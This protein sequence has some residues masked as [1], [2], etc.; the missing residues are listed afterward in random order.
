MA[1]PDSPR[2]RV[3]EF[4]CRYC[5]KHFKRLEHV[6]RHERTHTREAPFQC[7]CG[8]AFTRRSNYRSDKL[9]SILTIPR[10]LLTRHEKSAHGGMSRGRKV[11]KSAGLPHPTFLVQSDTPHDPE[12]ER[13]SQQTTFQSNTNDRVDFTDEDTI[14]VTHDISRSIAPS[15]GAEYTQ[16]ASNPGLGLVEQEANAFGVDA[17]VPTFLYDNTF[18][19]EH[20]VFL[21]DFD[22]SYFIQ[23]PFQLPGDTNTI[24]PGGTSAFN[25]PY[26]DP[27]DSAAEGPEDHTAS[28]SRFGS[29][30]PS[31]EPHVLSRTRRKTNNV[32]SSLPF[33]RK[34]T[35]EEYRAIE[36]KV[37]DWGDFLTKNFEL[38]S[39]HTLSR[40]FEGCMYG[41]FE[42]LPFVHIPTFSIEESSLELLLSIAAIGAEFRFERTCAVELFYAA[43]AI[44]MSPKSGNFYRSHNIGSLYTVGGQSFDSGPV[45]NNL[46]PNCNVSLEISS[47]AATSNHTLS[48]SEHRLQRIQAIL[49]IMV[50]GSWSEKSLVREA[51]SLQ[52]MLALLVRE[53]NLMEEDDSPV[54]YSAGHLS[55][56]QWRTWARFE[57]RRRTKLMAFCFLNLQSLAYNIP[58]TILTSEVNGRL[59]LSAKEWKA[60]T[61]QKWSR[62]YRSTRLSQRSFQESLEA[63]FEESPVSSNSPVSTVSNY[64]LIHALLQRIL[65]LRQA[66]HNG[67]KEDELDTKA[68]REITRALHLWQKQWELSPE[69]NVESQSPAGPVAF[70]STPLLRLAWIRLQSDLGPCRNLASRDPMLIASA[71]RQS[72]PLRR[73]SNLIQSVL[74][75]AYALSVPVR[76]GVSFVSK[77]QTVSWS[78]QHSLCNFECAI[79]LS[80]WFEALA[81][82]VLEE[83][84]TLEEKAL[85]KMIRT[86]INESGIFKKDAF[87]VVV[88]DESWQTS[89]HRLSTAVA[90]IWAEI[91]KGTHVFDVVNTISASLTI[92]AETLEKTHSPIGC[93]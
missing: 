18:L 52:S 40:F 61:A 66:S 59:P 8:R 63:L 5:P 14:D 31:L 79:F 22:I 49:S 15:F 25:Q 47:S 74:Q 77:T 43:R 75:A 24:F 72:P 64:A 46:S 83:P 34:I 85:I 88:D 76:L 57:S 35:A 42:H 41:L 28:L 92:Y 32:T 9:V 30:L 29:P 70:N 38:P 33:P 3:T 93:F 73:S 68:V 62:T 12:L 86:M 67:I 48:E 10:D 6:Q 82:T 39:R 50:M 69:S 37:Q 44:I 54:D 45:T 23:Q 53:D 17:S 87:S 20:N 11:A 89:I 90:R 80:K 26:N 7:P 65:N 71:F 81:L 4:A 78:V 58:P 27:Y 91:F 21:D 56:S 51:L 36:A 1:T 60:P 16:Q 55:E 13:F 2:R 19:D 84:L